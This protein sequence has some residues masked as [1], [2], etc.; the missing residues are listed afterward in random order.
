MTWRVELD[1]RAERELE[2][3]PD[4][5]LRRVVQRV[6]RLGEHP[7]PH[8][9]KKLKGTGGYRLR[10]GDFRVLYDVLPR[11]KLVIVYAVRHRRDVYR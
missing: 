10:V 5:T 9:V 11:E 6:R 2:K 1:R 8:G 4:E 7:F 3:L